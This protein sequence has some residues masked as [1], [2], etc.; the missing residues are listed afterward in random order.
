MIKKPQRNRFLN[1]DILFY[2]LN[3]LNEPSKSAFSKSY[4]CVGQSSAQTCR[5]LSKLRE[6]AA[7]GN[8]EKV[9]RLAT[10]RPDLRIPVLFTLAGLGAQD[11]MEAILIN[12]PE[13]LL[14][15]APLRDISGVVFES[16]SLFQ[17]AIWAM[18]V[19]YMTEMMLKCL[20]QN[21]RGEK[22]R[23]K[24]QSQ[25]Q[26]LKREGISYTL[27]G[28]KYDQQHHFNL[29]SLII[30][31]KIYVAKYKTW[32]EKEKK[33]YW[34][35]EVG[36]A[37]TMLPACIRHHYC[38]P[39]ETLWDNPS[40]TKKMLKRTLQIYNTKSGKTLLWSENIAALGKTLGLRCREA[41][42]DP[43]LVDETGPPAVSKDLMALENLY[44]VRMETDLPALEK[45]LNTPIIIQK[46]NSI[47]VS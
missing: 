25:Y 44:K 3:Y 21:E 23:V 35:T 34:S 6:Y 37:Q 26:K 24:L 39:E 29:E 19:R 31:I 46:S 40:F 20:P 45:L 1:S 32:N 5:L 47:S 33:T 36:L 2:I 43:A 30:K 11:E 10:I 9:A 17:H 41:A 8:I 28:V 12:N 16:I 13:D 18:D 4:F 27:H 22:I 14:V 15:E 38:D 42:G 7:Q